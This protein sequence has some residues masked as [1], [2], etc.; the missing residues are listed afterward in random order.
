MKISVESLMAILKKLFSKSG[1]D[2]DDNR[3]RIFLGVSLCVIVPV[4][5]IFSMDDIVAGR[6]FSILLNVLAVAILIA[7]IF[8]LRLVRRGLA[9]FRLCAGSML[10]MLLYFAWATPYCGSFAFHRLYSFCWG[11]R[12]DCCGPAAPSL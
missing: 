11:K 8:L 7:C 4:L 5:I 2:K 10:A 9:I 3:R 1:L 6:L 12:R